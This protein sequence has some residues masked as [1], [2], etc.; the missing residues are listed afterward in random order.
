MDAMQAFKQTIEP[1][2]HPKL[3]KIA[4]HHC[5]RGSGECHGGSGRLCGSRCLR[6]SREIPLSSKTNCGGFR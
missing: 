4:P 3:V 6:R 2:L 1:W 5:A